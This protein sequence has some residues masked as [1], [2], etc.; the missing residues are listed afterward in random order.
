MDFPHLRTDENFPNANGVDVYRYDNDLDYRRYDYSQMKICVCRVPWDMG[1]AHVG[2]RT[3][4]GIGNVVWFGSENARDTWF[5]SIPDSECFRW[6]TKFKELHRDGQITVPLPFDVAAKYNYLTVEYELF[7]NDGSLV[8]YEKPGG[9]RKWFWFIREVEF[10]APNSTRLILMNDAW[11]TFIYGVNI[12]W[13]VLERGHAPMCKVSADRYLSNPLQFSELV[14]AD[15]VN[16]GDVPRIVSDTESVMFNADNMKAVII[17][18]C[19]PSGDF[20]SKGDGD[21]HTTSAYHQAESVISYWAF[22]IDVANLQSWVTGVSSDA[23]Q[24]MRTVKA[25]CFISGDMLTLGASFTFGSVTCRWVSAGY[26]VNRLA[27]LTKE[28]FGYG[29]HYEDVAKLYTYPYCELVIY[30]NAGTEKRIRVEDTDG[31]LDVQSCVNLVY[32]WLKVDAH[33]RGVGRAGAQTFT[34]TNITSRNMPVQGNWR[35]TL[36]EFD[37]PTF[38]INQM[39]MAFNDYDTHFDRVQQLHA[40]NN[41]Y[42]NAAANADNQVANAGVTTAGNTAV[43]AASNASMNAV[44]SNAATYNTAKATADNIVTQGSAMSTIAAN[45]MQGTIAATSGVA[46]SALGALASGNPVGAV[47]GLVGGIIGAGATLASTAVANGLTSAMASYQIAS[48]N[49]NATLSTGKTQSDTTAHTTAASDITNANNSVV[50]SHAANNSATIYAN[51]ARDL[52]TAQNAVDNQQL[53]AALNAP[54]EFGEWSA[55]DHAVT[56]PMG[57]FLDV[58]TQAPGAIKRAGDEFM[59]YGYAL[60]RQWPFDGNW[61][62]GKHFTY[63]KLSDF[64]VKGLDVPDLYMDKLRFF[65]FGGVTVWKRPEDIGHVSIYQNV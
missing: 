15:D 17:S 51:A 2:Q 63:W 28:M 47:A 7:A 65:L 22:A 55:G 40:A 10:V 25:V 21:W 43:T 38:G 49:A 31:K 12:P 20:G 44:A 32:P 4:S 3:I 6:E 41:A 59:R 53:Q 37:I 16:F 11:Q 50:T 62:P 8:E 57:A 34:F 1:E 60:N 14:T 35:D 23:P 18:S 48:N 13:M 61:C 56:R 26:K 24:F 64:W 54:Q 45:E 46:S 42:S 33:I 19:D 29:P 30:D 27:T 36:I 9:V 58:V 52:D 5:D 39:A